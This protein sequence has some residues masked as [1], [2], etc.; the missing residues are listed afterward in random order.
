MKGLLTLYRVPIQLRLL[1]LKE[2]EGESGKDPVYSFFFF[3]FFFWRGGGVGVVISI[4]EV[5]IN[6]KADCIIK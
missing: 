1:S 2:L 5:P 3:F 4:K 6:R